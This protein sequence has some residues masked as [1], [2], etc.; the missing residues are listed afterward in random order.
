MISLPATGRRLMG[1]FARSFCCSV[2][3]SYL[4][5]YSCRVSAVTV[6][7]T[8]LT[9]EPGSFSLT[10]LI[11]PIVRLWEVEKAFA[12]PT[13]RWSL[14]LSRFGGSAGSRS[15]TRRPQQAWKRP[16]RQVQQPGAAPPSR[17][18]GT[19]G[20][21]FAVEG[22]STDIRTWIRATPSPI[23][24]SI[25]SIRALR[26]SVMSF[27]TQPRQRGKSRSVFSVLSRLTNSLT[28]CA[29]LMPSLCST[30]RSIAASSSSAESSLKA[31]DIPRLPVR[32]TL[33]RKRGMAQS[34]SRRTALAWARSRG[35]QK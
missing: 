1:K 4:L 23:A 31:Q 9:V 10:A 24:W 11:W 15:A 18:D 28:S 29:V 13:C 32:T 3:G 12:L 30:I 20:G 25:I 6:A 22:S 35:C 16:L 21:H 8:S 2:L 7:R 27:S 26:P 17:R 5:K 19:C 33:L 14:T 34:R